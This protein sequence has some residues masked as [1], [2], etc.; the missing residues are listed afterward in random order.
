MIETVLSHLL[1]DSS[2]SNFSFSAVFGAM[3]SLINDNW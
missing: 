3:L 2:Y 1:I